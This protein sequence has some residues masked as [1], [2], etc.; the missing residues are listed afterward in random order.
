MEKG[1]G[2]QTPHTPNDWRDQNVLQTD[3]HVNGVVL[4]EKKVLPKTKGG[5]GWPP[6]LRRFV[7]GLCRLDVLGLPPL[8]ALYHVELHLLAFLQT[9]ESAR[10]NRREV[11]KHVLAALTADKTI[12]LGI[13][14]PLYC[15]CFHGVARF[16]LVRYALCPSQNFFRQV[17]LLSRELLKTAKIKRSRIVPQMVLKLPNYFIIR[18]I[19]Y[20]VST[21]YRMLCGYDLCRLETFQ[22]SLHHG[23]MRL[24]RFAIVLLL[25]SLA[26]ADIVEDVRSALDQRNFTAADSQ[27][28]T[29]RAQHGVDAE[30]LEALSWTARAALDVNQLAQADAAAKQTE[31]LARQLL[32]KRSLDAEPH[33]PIALGAAF[34]VQAQV[35]AAHGQNG[36]AAALL[37]HALVSYG[38]TSISPRL[39][40]NLNLLSLTSELAPPL[41][42]SEYL[43]SR[44]VPLSQLKGSPVL[45]FFWAHWC[46][47]CK[48][49]GPIIARL[50][51]EF[52]AKGLTVLAPTQLYGYAAKGE[53]AKPK[54]ETA[55]IGQVWEHFYPGL[56]SVPVPI[57]KTNFTNYGASTTPTLVLVDRKGR[58]ALYHPGLMEYDALRGAIEKTLSN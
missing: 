32:Q 27:L 14:K 18:G 51:S 9:A 31:T 4:R 37:R 6:C 7:S 23:G 19:S 10:L 50:S 52:A 58:V 48:Y 11:D 44:P 41:T 24:R 36:Q 16:L 20:Y 13:V 57:S 54:D 38:K 22:T 39:H 43:G 1:G 49:E 8:G 5:L 30:Y 15:S 42:T 25:S 46:G 29:Y 28:Q 35:L 45:L 47:D 56:Q 34:E 26:C 17:T 55:Y 40:K 12:A 53:D 21:S 2:Q 3:G 33:L